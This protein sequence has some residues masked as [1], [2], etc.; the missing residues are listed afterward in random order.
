MFTVEAVLR[1]YVKYGS[2]NHIYESDVY[3]G[4]GIET[5]SQSDVC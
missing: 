5:C 3:C 2:D 1:R 4:S